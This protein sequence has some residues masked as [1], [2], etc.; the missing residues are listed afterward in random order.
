MLALLATGDAFGRD[1]PHTLELAEECHALAGEQVD[2][3]RATLPGVD[4]ELAV[5][6]RVIVLGR[7]GRGINRRNQQDRRARH[8]PRR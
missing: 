8:E 5:L 7:R 2:R 4:R 3:P 1:A 6:A